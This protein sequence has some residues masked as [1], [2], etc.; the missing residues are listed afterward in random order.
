MSGHSKNS[1]AIEHYSFHDE[2]ECSRHLLRI[3]GKIQEEIKVVEEC[4]IL[5][6]KR[7]NKENISKN[8]TCEFCGYPLNEKSI[9]NQEVKKNDEIEK[10]KE[11]VSAM[12]ELL[13]FL[14]KKQDLND[15]KQALIKLKQA[16]PW[17]ED[18]S[19]QVKE[20][21]VYARSVREVE[22]IAGRIK[23]KN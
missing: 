15:M 3:E 19:G 12:Q 9:I 14:V 22:R 5:Q 17:K 10:L 8:E 1:R 23:I 21:V 4:P 20:G 16:D 11:S 18:L 6:C 7:C 2:N 13:K